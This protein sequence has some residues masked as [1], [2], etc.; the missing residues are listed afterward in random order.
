MI[1]VK[2]KMKTIYKSFLSL[3]G[4][5]LFFALLLGITYLC[6]DKTAENDS[7]IEVNGALSINYV[8]G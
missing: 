3:I 5:L 8:S 2:L 1:M 6:F 4:I 7:D